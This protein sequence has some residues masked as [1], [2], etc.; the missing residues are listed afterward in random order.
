M[1]SDRRTALITYLRDLDLPLLSIEELAKVTGS[2]RAYLDKNRDPLIKTGYPYTSFEECPWLDSKLSH[3]YYVKVLPSPSRDDFHQRVDL[4]PDNL[5]LYTTRCL[6]LL[7]RPTEL[8]RLEKQVEEAKRSYPWA[9]SW[10]D[11]FAWGDVDRDPVLIFDLKLGD[12]VRLEALRAKLFA[13]KT[14][15]LDMIVH[16]IGLN[17][18]SSLWVR[19]LR[20]LTDTLSADDV[21]FL[22][23]MDRIYTGFNVRT[24][25]IEDEH[26]FLAPGGLSSLL[27]VMGHVEKE[28]TIGTLAKTREALNEVIG[29]D[30]SGRP[31]LSVDLATAEH[32]KR[33][34]LE[35]V[36]EDYHLLEQEEKAFWEEYRQR[37]NRA[38]EEEFY[39]EIVIRTKVKRR[40]KHT[41][42]PYVRTFTEF[43]KSHQESTGHPPPLEIAAPGAPERAAP[44]PPENSFRLNGQVWEV[45][46]GGQSYSIKNTLGIRYLRELIQKQGEDVFVV[47]LFYK[48]NGVPPAVSGP[49]YSHMTEEQLANAGLR[50]TGHENGEPW[51]TPDGRRQIEKGSEGGPAK[52]GTPSSVCVKQ[53]LL[54][55]G[56]TC[57]NL[58]RRAPRS[59][60]ISGEQ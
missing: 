44:L 8:H 59:V 21:D 52:R 30:E 22:L 55:F 53:L 26:R 25:K 40:H 49:E 43:A 48:V 37:V 19:C 9:R 2:F 33:Q 16:A 4:S 57:G 32:P 17:D 1:I 47:D 3:L 54:Q 27:E 60:R 36:L 20:V 14:H 23:G 39:E 24:G 15:T 29:H 42:E 5:D 50:V 6:H 58:R 46:L 28:L 7:D 34:V 18:A 11:S 41:F 10:Y 38:L 51:L 35:A 31:R 45:R 12:T 56:A 13:L